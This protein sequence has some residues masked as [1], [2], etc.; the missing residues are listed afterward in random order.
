[1]NSG[2]QEFTWAIVSIK[3]VEPTTREP[4]LTKKSSTDSPGSNAC[5]MA[6]IRLGDMARIEED[7]EIGENLL[8]GGHR[9]HHGHKASV[10]GARK[11]M[12]ESFLQSGSSERAVEA[13]GEI[14]SLQSARV[15]ELK[16]RITKKSSA[17]P[18]AQQTQVV[19]PGAFTDGSD[20]NQ[21]SFFERDKTTKLGPMCFR[22]RRCQ[23]HLQASV[24]KLLRRR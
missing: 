19:A 17:A 22:R 4:S 7:W 24:G 13:Y 10:A 16:A 20:P 21:P 15:N 12:A 6:R 18:I 5:W 23:L 8:P 14:L 2:Y 3:K 1:M 11:L 9:G